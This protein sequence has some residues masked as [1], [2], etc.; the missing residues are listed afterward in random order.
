MDN[1][2]H[3]LTGLM[4]S[5][6]GLNRLTPHASAIAMIAANIPDIDV[7]SGFWGAP[8]YFH[9]H[10]WY[11]HAWLLVPLMA[12]LPVLI[13]SLFAKKRLPWGKAYL[14]SLVAAASHPLLDF[15]NP[16]GIR[17]LAPFSQQWPSL[18]IVNV[19]DLWIWAVL[20]L[21]AAWPSL[22]GLVS[23]EIGAR[24]TQGRG[25]AIFAL[26]FLLLYDGARLLLKQQAIALQESRMYNN[27]TPRRV[28][29]MP[30]AANPLRWNGVVETDEFFVLQDVDLRGD[31][32]PTLGRILYKRPG[33][34]ATDAAQR[35]RVFEDMMGFS[36]SLLWQT[37]PDSSSEGAHR[38]EATDLRFGFT[39]FAIVNARNE[40][41]RTGFAFGSPNLS[42]Q[43][44]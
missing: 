15:T 27:A 16:Y 8:A 44:R 33:N 37:L 13:V 28:S 25:W 36:K 17:F 23:S 7:I 32:D 18:D 31:F 26:S 22:S 1:I 5:R 3:T 38:V 34:A 24:K 21:A 35:T 41:E 2:T 11:T 12:V 4:L 30:N 20:F 10:R 29:V 39:A 9:C 14:V 19:F 43:P 6:A 40:V 42:I